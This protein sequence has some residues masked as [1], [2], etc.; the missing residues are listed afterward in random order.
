MTVAEPAE[1]PDMY[2]AYPRLGE[3]H[4]TELHRYGTRR[5]TRAGEVLLAGDEVQD[6]VV[7]LEGRVS[8]VQDR[9]RA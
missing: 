5:T 7:I 8:V 4:L 1:T 6:F 2:G 9:D 3:A